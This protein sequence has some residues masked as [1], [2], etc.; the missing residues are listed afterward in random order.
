[1]KTSLP[2]IENAIT[3]TDPAVED[4]DNPLI[5]D[6]PA[7]PTLLEG[8]RMM[9]RAGALIDAKLSPEEAVV[10]HAT[11]VF[12]PDATSA[13]I[14]INVIAQVRSSYHDRDLRL[15]EYRNYAITANSFLHRTRDEYKQYLPSKYG[16]APG[17]RARGIMVVAPVRMG[18]RQIADVVESFIGHDSRPVRIYSGS[19]FSEY[20]RLRTLRVQWPIAG[21]TSGLLTGFIGAFD[22][23]IDSK[24]SGNAR[25]HLFRE[26]RIVATM[27]SFGVAASLGLLIV[28][29][30][31]VEDATTYASQ[32]TWSA[33]AKF[34]RLT[35]IPV[36]CLAT[37][38]AAAYGLA[39][40][41]SAGGNLTSTGVTEIAPAL[42]ERDKHW[43]DICR[44]L[45][46]ATILRAG[47]EEMPGWFP[48]LAYDLTAGYPGLLAKALASIALQLL[49]LG[50]TS[51]TPKL[52]T[53]Y[54]K[55]ALLLDRPHIDAVKRIRDGLRAGSVFKPSSLYRHSDWLTLSEILPSH[56]WPEQI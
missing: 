17:A 8:M 32:S 31:T 25:S 1:M 28:E 33:L 4:G 5:E 15:P 27:C 53:K 3:L 30:I 29:G 39:K 14:L 44:A 11:Q 9:K 56:P 20:H 47:T 18:R 48:E 37:P 40:V 51:F 46:N 42:H 34:T 21:K 43:V 26:E 55:E 36:L 16:V 12:V 50:T 54:G 13:Q 35:G 23:A 38:G 22:T 49:S 6:I 24:Y 45:Y 52:F 41:P 2:V 7:T 10:H 19:G